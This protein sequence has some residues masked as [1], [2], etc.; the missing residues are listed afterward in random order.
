M[1]QQKEK[2][3]VPMV[4][5]SV[6]QEPY[7]PGYSASYTPEAYT[8]QSYDPQMY[9]PQPYGSEPQSYKQYVS[10]PYAP[11]SAW[12]HPHLLWWP[13]SSPVNLRP[14]SAPVADRSSPPRW[15]SVWGA[16]P[17]PSR[18]ACVWWGAAWAAVSSPSC[19]N[20]VRTSIIIVPVADITST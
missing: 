12:T 6:P 5:L 9:A 4:T 20:A 3:S 18:P 10:D 15:S 14:P 19:P 17:M 11:N 7:A 13:G 2:V 8:S 1:S 16:S